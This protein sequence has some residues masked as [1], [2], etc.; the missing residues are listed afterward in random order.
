[1]DLNSEILQFKCKP[2]K[3]YIKTE[4]IHYYDIKPADKVGVG[5][6]INVQSSEAEAR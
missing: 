5:E 3:S 6:I 1:M 2:I 4:L